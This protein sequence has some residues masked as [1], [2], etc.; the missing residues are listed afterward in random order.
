MGA[1]K[2]LVLILPVFLIQDSVVAHRPSKQHPIDQRKEA[3]YLHVLKRELH[4]TAEQTRTR[5]QREEQVSK[6][7][8]C[9]VQAY[10]HTHASSNRSPFVLTQ[11]FLAFETI[12]TTEDAYNTYDTCS[13]TA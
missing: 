13:N 11:V 2:A 4:E 1:L 9:I 3:F 8:V 7:C 10:R 6:N 12:I 5:L